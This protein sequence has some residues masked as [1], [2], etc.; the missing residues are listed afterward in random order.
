MSTIDC[1]QFA[2]QSRDILGWDSEVCVTVEIRLA[3]EAFFE[4]DKWPN[5]SFTIDR[6]ILPEF[7]SSTPD[8]IVAVP[9]FQKNYG[10]DPEEYREH[11]SS[12]DKTLFV[13]KVDG[14]LV[15]YVAVRRNWNGL[16]LIDDLAVELSMRRKGIAKSLM[17]TAVEWAKQ[18]GLRGVM[19]ETQTNNVAACL[20]YKRYGF[21]LG[22]ID[23]CLYAGISSQANEIA[24]FWYLL[25]SGSKPR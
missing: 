3:D 22:G 9:A 24:L 8:R 20:F 2:V 1:F 7:W 23:R 18:S 15:G 10:G 6:E 16:A 14:S 17:D 11:L 5:F 12:A 19:L 21:V 4:T 13:A 25:F